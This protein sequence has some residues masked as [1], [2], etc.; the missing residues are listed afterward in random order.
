MYDLIQMKKLPTFGGQL[1][2]DEIRR[3]VG[4]V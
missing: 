1:S 2:G 3:N 4:K